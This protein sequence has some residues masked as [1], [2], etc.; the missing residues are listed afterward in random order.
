MFWEYLGGGFPRRAYSINN[1]GIIAKKE[2]NL[3]KA[4]LQFRNAIALKPDYAGAHFNLGLL[5]MEKKDIDGAVA[6][7][8]VAAKLAP[9]ED[10]IKKYLNQ[11]IGK[12]W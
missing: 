1:L 11:L 2:G 8:Q 6:E 9:N 3:Q 4:E 5:L 10:K 7:L 12:K